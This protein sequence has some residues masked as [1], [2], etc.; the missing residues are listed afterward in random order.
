M[1]TIRSSPVH[2][3]PR[4]QI[5]SPTQYDD[6]AED[7][8]RLIRPRYDAIAAR[9]RDFVLA[10]RD[11]REAVVL[12]LSAGT[13]ALTRQLAPDAGGGYIATDVSPGMLQVA[14][15]RCGADEPIAWVRADVAEIPLRSDLA[16]LVVSSLGPVQ[17]HEESLAEAR[18]VLTPGGRLVACTWGDDYAELRLM[19]AA[20]ALVGMEPRPVTTAQD[21]SGIARASGFTDVAVTSFRLP[22][23]HASL[24]AYTAYRQAFGAMPLPEGLTMEDLLGALR[25]AAAAYVDGAGR[26]VLDWHLLV[27]TASA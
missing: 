5:G 13:G 18:R 20:R 14:R 4:L 6:V 16:D 1:S 25:S 21:V 8:D 24:G 27:L 10:Q 11:L 7:Y 3:V 26:V 19:Q 12:E 23:T 15:R 9:V 17:D 2:T 22:V